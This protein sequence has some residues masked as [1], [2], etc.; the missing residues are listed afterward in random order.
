MPD[1]IDQKI[2][3]SW[4]CPGCGQRITATVDITLSM[5][6][7]ILGQITKANIRRKEVRLLTANWATVRLYCFNCGWTNWKKSESAVAEQ[8]ATDIHAREEGG[9]ED[10]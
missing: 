1:Q 10:L 4:Q 2:S 7:D 5:P 9:E 8:I 3:K 6:G